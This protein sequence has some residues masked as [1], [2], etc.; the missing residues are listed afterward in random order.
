MING[1]FVFMFDVCDVIARDRRSFARLDRRQGSERKG[2]LW[3]PRE[4]GHDVRDL[5]VAV[6]VGPSLTF[7]E[8]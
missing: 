4:F 5:Y 6:T 8:L 7:C 1:Y 2:T 3:N